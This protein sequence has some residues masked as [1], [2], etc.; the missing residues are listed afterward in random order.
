MELVFFLGS[1]ILILGCLGVFIG[2]HLALRR[3]TKHSCSRCLTNLTSAGRSTK[4][5]T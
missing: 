5:S 3:S 4:V 1:L 2:G